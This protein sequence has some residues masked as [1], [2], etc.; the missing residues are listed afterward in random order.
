MTDWTAEYTAL[1]LDHQQ[2]LAHCAVL[3]T[4][5]GETAE[6]VHAVAQLGEESDFLEVLRGLT[7]EANN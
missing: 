6:V 1:A 5:H 7:I 2:R 3:L 4:A